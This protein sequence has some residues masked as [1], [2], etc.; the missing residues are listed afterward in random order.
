MT[1]TKPSEP[2]GASTLP[3][4]QVLSQNIVRQSQSH[5]GVKIRPEEQDPVSTSVMSPQTCESRHLTRNLLDLFS[6][7]A[8]VFWGLCHCYHAG[9]GHFFP[10]SWLNAT[11]WGKDSS[12]FPREGQCYKKSKG[13]PVY[14]FF[15]GCTTFAPWRVESTCF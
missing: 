1:T 2:S 3:G 4:A 12:D 11:K 9:C 15:K 5:C 14:L 6:C 13:C 8:S 10:L 7:P